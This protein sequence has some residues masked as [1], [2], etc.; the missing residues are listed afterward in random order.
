MGGY[1]VRSACLLFDGRLCG[2]MGGYA[3][4]WAGMR[5]Y[6]LTRPSYGMLSETTH[7]RYQPAPRHH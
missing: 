3:V 7:D 1:A 4:L 2:C 5:F 6:G